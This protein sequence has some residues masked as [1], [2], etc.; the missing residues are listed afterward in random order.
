MDTL[1][2]MRKE[3]ERRVVSMERLQDLTYSDGW[4]LVLA[5]FNDHIQKYEQKATNRTLGDDKRVKALEAK[6]AL[7]DL[8]DEIT[9]RIEEGKVA[10]TSLK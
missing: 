5:M 9:K 10:K 2:R 4:L 7:V 8:L 1:T 3:L 6:R